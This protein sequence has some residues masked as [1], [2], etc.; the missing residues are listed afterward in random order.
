M[1]NE[2]SGVF[3]VEGEEF[4]EDIGRLQNGCKSGSIWAASQKVHMLEDRFE[5]SCVSATA[6]ICPSCQARGSQHRHAQLR[7]VLE[8]AKAGCETRRG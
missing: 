4:S 1:P 2:Q 3:G 7:G 8:V 5:L 6:R